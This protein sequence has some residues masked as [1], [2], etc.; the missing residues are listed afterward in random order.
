MSW[1]ICCFSSD[2]LLRINSSLSGHPKCGHLRGWCIRALAFQR[3]AFCYSS[4]T[5][6]DSR[7]TLVRG[8]IR[9]WTIERLMDHIFWLHDN[10][11]GGRPGP[12]LVPWN[13]RD[14]RDGGIGAVLSVN[15]GEL[16]HPED[17]NALE[18]GYCCAP[19][20]EHAPPRE[21]DL[22]TCLAS[23]PKG[24][25]FVLKNRALGRKTLVHCRQGRDRTGL[26]L[27]YYLHKQHG[28]SPEQA[29]I[30]LKDVRR[31]ALAAEGWG[32]FALQVLRAC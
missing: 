29:I 3:V 31:D 25:D 19:L 11:V 18:I 9:H 28:A 27:T 20:S 1:A 23:L 32:E 2:R 5:V 30:Q 24:L 22:E 14:L 15:D 21:G 12:N 7:R 26:F 8:Q 17:L 13:P 4:R 6:R 16:A 10:L